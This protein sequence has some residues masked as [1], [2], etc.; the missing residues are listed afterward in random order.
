MCRIELQEEDWEFIE[1]M[2]DRIKETIENKQ[3]PL[4]I[5]YPKNERKPAT[6]QV[7]SI[8]LRK[9]R[10]PLLNVG[11]VDR[12]YYGGTNPKQPRW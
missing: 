4:R 3:P 10:G 9:L 7:D 12:L 8:G 5:V 2:I 11:D 6:T 1:S